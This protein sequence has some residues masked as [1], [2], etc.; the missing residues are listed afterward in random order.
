[1]V[2]EL[3]YKATYNSLARQDHEVKTN[4]RLLE[5]QER[6]ESIAANIKKSSQIQDPQELQAQLQD[7]Q[8][9]VRVLSQ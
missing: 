8:E 5:K 6:I 7:I 3:C 9:M 1:M 2:L 4:Q